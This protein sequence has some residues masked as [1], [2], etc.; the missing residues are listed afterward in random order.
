LGLHLVERFFGE[1]ARRR[2]AVRLDGP[3]N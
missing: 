3:W 2:E 1:K